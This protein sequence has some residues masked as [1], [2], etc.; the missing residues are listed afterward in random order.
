MNHQEQN[1]HVTRKKVLVGKDLEKAQ[2][3]ERFPLQKSRW[4]KTKLTTMKHI[5]SRMSSYF[6]NRWRLSY[7]NL[8]Q[9]IKTYIRRQ[10][11]KQF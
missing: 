4:E 8:T 1:E 10:Q 7:L 11:H 5:V 3:E 2:S 9:I 6:P